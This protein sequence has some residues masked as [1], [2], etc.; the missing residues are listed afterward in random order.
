GSRGAAL[1]FAVRPAACRRSSACWPSSAEW[2]RST[3]TRWTSVPPVTTE[4]PASRTAGSMSRS[5]MMRAPSRV[6]RCRSANSSP[7]ATLSATALAAM[8][9]MSGGGGGWRGARV[10]E[11]EV[12]GGAAGDDGAAGLAEGGLHEPVGDD[13]RALGGTARPFGELL[14]RGDLERDGLGGDDVHE[15]A[16]LLAGE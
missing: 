11:D 15:R 10:E 12:D 8:T 1:R 6:R 7:A 3:R 13:A 5:A 16:A 4:T 2:R 9:C 14:A